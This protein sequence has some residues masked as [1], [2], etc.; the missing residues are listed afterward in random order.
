MCDVMTAL[1]TGLG[2]ASQ[3]AKMSQQ[4][5]QQ[6]AAARRASQEAAYRRAQAVA[7][8][9][10]IARE[11]LAA[12]EEAAER[13]QDSGRE[14][15]KTEEK[16]RTRAGEAGASGLSL[17]ALARDVAGASARYAEDL[18]RRSELRELGFALRAK[19]AAASTQHSLNQIHQ[20]TPPDYFAMANRGLTTV[21]KA[22]SKVVKD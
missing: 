18:R 4:K 21:G 22:M 8:Y 11:R 16:L 5:A 10:E 13:L 17:Q 1:T 15:L 19:D 3:A 7:R 14:A 6:T 2:L 12:R 9:D 20:P